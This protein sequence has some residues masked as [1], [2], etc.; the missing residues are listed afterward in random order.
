VAPHYP[1][2][3]G[4]QTILDA[5]KASETVV[6]RFFEILLTSQI[7]LR[8]WHGGE[9]T[10]TSFAFWTGDMVYKPLAARVALIA[11]FGGLCWSSDT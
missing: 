2:I 10:G 4:D 8:D 11:G 6:H 9:S 5:E 3:R 1:G 7:S